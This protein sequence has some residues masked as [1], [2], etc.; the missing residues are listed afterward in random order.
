MNQYVT[1]TMIKLCREAKKITQAELAH[2]LGVSDKAVS[3]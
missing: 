1:G 3:K 2:T